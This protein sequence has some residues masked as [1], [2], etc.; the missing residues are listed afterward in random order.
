MLSLAPPPQLLLLAAESQDWH[1]PL[2]FGSIGN[3]G[4]R[5][6]R[7]GGGRRRRRRR[8][9]HCCSRRRCRQG[10]LSGNGARGPYLKSRFSRNSLALPIH[11]S[12]FPVLLTTIPPA[13]IR[14]SSL[15]VVHDESAGGR[16][17]RCAAVCGG[18]RTTAAGG[19]NESRRASRIRSVSLPPGSASTKWS[20]EGSTESRA[21]TGRRPGGVHA[22]LE[23]HSSSLGTHSPGSSGDPAGTEFEPKE[24]PEH[25][26]ASPTHS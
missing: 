17:G 2:L 6:W 1:P 3:G 7:R 13:Q 8:G 18:R 4:G 11:L 24:S 16:G 5:A 23:R 20:V 22:T 21:F 19:S 25:S 14:W 12:R 9:R 10:C 26:L 15:P